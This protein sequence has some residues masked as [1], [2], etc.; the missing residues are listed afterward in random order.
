M[1]KQTKH[2]MEKIMRD[3]A[4][5]AE[6][7]L[8]QKPRWYQE[9]I[10]RHPHNR[11]VLRCGRRLGKCI[12]G[13]Q[14]MVNPET[15]E[16]R[17]LNDLF[18]EGKENPVLTVSD[19]YRVISG[20]SIQIEDNGIKKVFAVKLKHGSEVKL[21]GNHPVLTVDG[22]KE[23]DALEIGESI[24]TPKETGVF[25]K[26][27]PGIARAK[28]LGYITGGYKETKAGPALTIR[29]E[30]IA[31]DI[32]A[33]A[34]QED[35]LLVKKSKQQYLFM[36]K[37]GTYRPVTTLE[38]KEVPDEVFR[39]DKEH[40]GH[41]LSAFY[42]VAGWKYAHRITEIGFST[43]SQSF[44]RD[45]KHLLLRFGI[46]VNL[47]NR[48]ID[49]KDAVQAFIYS[50]NDTMAFC[51]KL[52]PYSL[53]DYTD[54]KEKAQTMM[55]KSDTL[56][57][58]VW[59][60]I[61][62]R[63]KEL[64]MKKKEVTG[65]KDERMRMKERLPKEAANRYAENLQFPWLYDL[66]AR[67]IL[68]EEVTAIADVGEEQTYDVMVPDTHN[69]LVEDI[70]V[71]NTWTMSAHMLWGVFTGMG[72][73]ITGRGARAVVATP[74][75]NQA[76]LIYDQLVEFIK[77]NEVLKSSVESMTKNPYFIQFKNGGTIK[78]FTAGTRSGSGGASL[79]GQAADLLYMDKYPCPLAV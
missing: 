36:D 59:P 77:N 72:G 62:K 27:A 68:W 17:T 2:Q 26:D 24:A 56:P 39:Y 67:D 66:A 21:T 14:R 71:H 55:E 3:P 4:L 58:E 49:G 25:G 28:L 1:D 73:K 23:V 42:D 40:L 20:Q 18:K 43:L 7:H 35:V 53:K 38:E 19:D 41:F 76:K 46:D 22:W 10:L 47:V 52:A 31:G 34:E 32:I 51:Q 37:K 63:R 64:K 16:Y 44:A 8:G 57:V 11:V 5:W 60:Y 48:R 13:S 78:L 54:I 29:D 45:M 74:Y 6:H 61:E 79:R 50:R 33:L 9:Q 75:D 12:A 65:N 70:F 69:A 15:G 30:E